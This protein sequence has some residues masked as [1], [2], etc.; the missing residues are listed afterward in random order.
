MSI[1]KFLKDWSLLVGIVVGSLVYL[2]FTNVEF[3]VPIGDSCGPVLVS[4]LPVN[5]FLML[6]LTF[7]KIKVHDMRPRKWHFI[8]QMIRTSLA[9]LA[10]IGCNLSGDML[11]KISMSCGHA[12]HIWWSSSQSNANEAC[13]IYISVYEGNA[14]Y[15]FGTSRKIFPYDIRPI[16]AF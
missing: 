15:S 4:F 6:Y 1:V 13:Y 8:L 7:I 9:I 12:G 16:A 11:T 5:I 2:L 3:L 14:S 10:M